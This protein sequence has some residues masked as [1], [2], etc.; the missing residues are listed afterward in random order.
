VPEIIKSVIKTTRGTHVELK[1]D[2]GDGG[3]SVIE[4]RKRILLLG[5]DGTVFKVT[6]GSEH[7]RACLGVL[8]EKGYSI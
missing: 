1:I 3:E 4:P 7:G 5:A 8:K 2:W 6:R